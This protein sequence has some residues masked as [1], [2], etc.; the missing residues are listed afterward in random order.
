MKKILIF[1]ILLATL[2]ASCKN[3]EDYP[4]KGIDSVYFQVSENWAVVQDSINY[5]FAGKGLDEAVVWIRINLLGYATS[6]DR[7]V[8]VVVDAE[9]TTAK[10]GMHY[11]ALKDEYMLPAD[12]IY[13][14]LPVFIYNKDETL[15]NR[16]VVLDL[17]L[18]GTEDLQLGIAERTKVRLLINN[19]LKKP[20]YWERVLKYNFG[21]YSRTKHELCILQLGFD[22]PED[23]NDYDVNDPLWSVSG[24]YMS[25]YFEENYPVY[26][27]DNNI[28]EPW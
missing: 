23:V 19:M 24:Q 14:M 7:K 22:F 4:F 15:E 27:E 6:H 5:T 20:S 12:S 11:L 21:V 17:Q 16:S 25:N 28:I 26:D 8:C 13:L 1:S 10:E 18:E 3:N 9:E 2:C